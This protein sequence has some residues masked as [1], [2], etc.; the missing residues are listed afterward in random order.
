MTLD[1]S[2]WPAVS[3]NLQREQRKPGRFYHLLVH[4]GENTRSSGRFYMAVVQ[5]VLLL[6][7]ELWVV[8]PQIMWEL[9]VYIIG[10]WGGFMS[11]RLGVRTDNGVTPPLERLW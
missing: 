9:G 5:L 10:W 3:R 1:D 8:T 11:R 2:D 4:E 6:G 7:L